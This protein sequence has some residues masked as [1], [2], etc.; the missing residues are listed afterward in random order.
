LEYIRRNFFGR[1]LKDDRNGPKATTSG[2]GD[3]LS[4]NNYV[5]PEG[6]S[7]GQDRSQFVDEVMRNVEYLK[8]V[9][10]GSVSV[11]SH[12]MG[13]S[14]SPLGDATMLPVL[15]LNEIE[16]IDRPVRNFVVYNAKNYGLQLL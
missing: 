5:N 11:S 14:E 4:Y 13:I 7:R 15:K 3:S 10:T 1:F 6:V 16:Y 9:K 12:T 8:S 2:R